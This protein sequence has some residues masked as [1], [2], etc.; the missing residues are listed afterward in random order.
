M[1]VSTRPRGARPWRDRGAPTDIQG[2]TVRDGRSEHREG[3]VPVIL[4][5]TGDKETAKE[6]VVG[7]KVAPEPSAPRFSVPISCCLH[8]PQ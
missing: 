4:G 8:K 6:I 5:E 3:M 2:D 1:F 7:T